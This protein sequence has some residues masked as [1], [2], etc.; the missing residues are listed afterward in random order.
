M[1]ASLRPLSGSP[2]EG[3]MGAASV[4]VMR[5]SSGSRASDAATRLGQPRDVRQL[6]G[7][8]LGEEREERLGRDPSD[9]AHPAQRGRLAL[10]CEVL[11]DE[12]D[13][14]PVLVGQLDPD[15]RGEG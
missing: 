4:V 12:P 10:V 13:R 5:V 15:L 1:M 3:T 9:G 6:L 11:A 7:R 14:L 2:N 8:L